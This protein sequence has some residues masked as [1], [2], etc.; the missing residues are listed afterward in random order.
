MVSFGTMEEPF[1]LEEGRLRAKGMRSGKM[2][3]MG[4]EVQIRIVAT[5]LAKRQ[6]DM[7]FA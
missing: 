2:L 7:E 4:D 5:E 6:I 1:D 3:K